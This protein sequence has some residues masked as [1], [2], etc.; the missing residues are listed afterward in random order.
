FVNID[1]PIIDGGGSGVL[2]GRNRELD[3]TIHDLPDNTRATIIIPDVSPV[4]N[5]IRLNP[6]LDC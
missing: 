4:V 6:C 5:C 2:R 3:Y 1:S